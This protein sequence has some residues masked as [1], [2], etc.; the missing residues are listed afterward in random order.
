MLLDESADEIVGMIIAISHID[1]SGLIQKTTSR[2]K[3]LRKEL[4]VLV[5]VVF[6]ALVNKDLHRATKGMRVATRW[7]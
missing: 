3:V 2:V 1:F 7:C 4:L 5:E 6:S